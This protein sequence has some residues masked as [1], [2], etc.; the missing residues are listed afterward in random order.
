MRYR[1]FL[2]ISLVSLLFL[3]ACT[4]SEDVTPIASNSSTTNSTSTVATTA[5][6]K[7]SVPNGAVTDVSVCAMT[8]TAPAGLQIFPKTN[9]WNLNV[10]GAP[11]DPY[12]NQI[13]ANLGAAH[14]WADF[15]SGTWNGAPIGIPFAVV[16]GSQAKLPVTYRANAMD[17]NYSSESDPGPMPIPANCP[18]EMN[19]QQDAHVIVLDKDNQM[20]YELYNASYSNGQWYASSGAKF[21]VATGALRPDNWTAAD[22][23][24][25]PIYPGLVKYD[26]MASGLITHA[27]RFTLARNHVRPGMHVTPARHSSAG[28]GG[29]YTLPFG[30]RIRL[31]WSYDI[32]GFPPHMQ[33]ILRAMKQYGLILADLGMDM[34]IKGAP[35][36]R[37]NN[38]ELRTL[39]KLT[40]SDFE[41]VKFE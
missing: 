41:V 17:G 9:W 26:E 2:S 33:V 19:G 10:A 4:K 28:T 21:N 25:L 40:A 15:G 18:I 38:A 16:C 23:A 37:W 20:L 39:N 29:Q 24:G 7:L 11:L 22:A 30:A 1:P 34:Y 6:K 8:M 12:S 36:S 32:S 31:K 14:A 5:S 3:G 27:I 35:D 13:I